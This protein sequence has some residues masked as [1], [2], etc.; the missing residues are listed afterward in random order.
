[1]SQQLQQKN[2]RIL[3]SWLPLVMLGG[4]VFF[5]FLMRGHILHMQEQQLHLKQNDIWRAFLQA[6]GVLPRHIRG[7]YDIVADPS[8]S[9]R[10]SDRPG[11][12]TLNFPETGFE[13]FSLLTSRLEAN[14]KSYLITT[15]ISSREFT[16]LIIKIALAEALIFLFLLGAVVIVNRKISNRLWSPFYDTME[17]I[18][19][20]DI[21]QHTSLPLSAQTGVDEFDRLNQTLRLLI[22]NVD[23]AY[24]NQKQFTENAAH[25]LQTPLA[26][27]RSKV[28]LMME[29]P[30]LTEEMAQLLGEISDANERLSQMGRNLL[31]LSRIENRQYPEGET[32][33]LSRLVEKQT[34]LFRDFYEANTSKTGTDIQ[35]GVFVKANKSLLEI[36]INNLL[37]NAYIHNLP[38]GYVEIKLRGTNLVVENSGPPVAGDPALLFDRFRKGREDARTTGLGLA[39]VKQICDF[40]HFDVSYSY[41]DCVHSVSVSFA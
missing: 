12:T 29:G 39:I 6:P 33:D 21:R 36:L 16:H 40:Y 4:S 32:V 27:I 26:I 19:R 28:E 34:A 37:R 1:M 22:E 20:F 18:R 5:Y 25:E 30:A 11:D 24:H 13:P 38:R 31:V 7:E 41:Q 17:S 15:Y 10:I 23:H 2:T 3:L 14:G 9:S 35:S 8:P